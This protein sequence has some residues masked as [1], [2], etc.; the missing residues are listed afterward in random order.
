[1]IS[2]RNEIQALNLLYKKAVEASEN[3]G[4]GLWL[5]K[6]AEETMD[7]M[8]FP[9]Y[10]SE[11][12]TS[13]SLPYLFDWIKQNDIRHNIEVSGEEVKLL[14]LLLLFWLGGR[15]AVGRGQVSGGVEGAGG[16]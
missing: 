14:P 9:E 4:N 16:P 15:R 1:M 5:R 3:G 6:K 13:S 10:Q 12:G 8:S 7:A 11:K 2:P